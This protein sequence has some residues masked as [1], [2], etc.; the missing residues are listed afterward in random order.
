MRRSPS[1]RTR[2]FRAGAGTSATYVP[3][4]VLRSTNP[5]RSNCAY[6]SSA[7]FRDTRMSAA[8]VRVDGNR[9][10]ALSVPPR[11]EARRAR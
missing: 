11:M 5:S 2:S 7:V 6:A 1:N 9:V 4:P 3:D 8:N 10:P